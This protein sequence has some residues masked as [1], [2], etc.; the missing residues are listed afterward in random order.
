MRAFARRTPTVV[1]TGLLALVLSIGTGAVWAALL[2]TNLRTDPGVPW[3]VAVMALLLWLMWAYLGGRGRPHSTAEARRRFLRARRVPRPVFVWALVAGG[4]SLAALTG[5]WP[6]LFQLVRMQGNPLPDFSRYPLTTVVLAIAM[7]SLATAVAEEAGFRGYF[8]SALEAR[9][10]APLAIL[11]AALVMAPGH[12]LT[13]GFGWPTVLFYL[14]VDGMLGLI[15]YLTGSILPGLLVHVTGLVIF[16]T[17]IWPYDAAR[18][19]VTEAGADAW[20][21]LRV[22][23]I[24]LFAALAL[25]AFRKLALTARSSRAGQAR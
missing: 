4:L 14:L 7:G 8:Q 3:S 25:L 9:V 20:F 23:Q 22:M 6:V 10:A 1:W 16:F 24:V 15:A 13:Q 12:G 21:W 2:L 11:I 5:L 19:L 17:L 18:P